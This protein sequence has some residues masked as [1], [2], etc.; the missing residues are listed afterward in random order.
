MSKTKTLGGIFAAI[1][2]ALAAWFGMSPS[3]GPG[4]SPTPTA[5]ATATPEPTPEPTASPTPTPGPLPSPSVP[6]EIDCPINPQAHE[7]EDRPDGPLPFREDI[8]NAINKAMAAGFVV[9]GKIV[10]EKAYTDAVARF[11][12]QVGVCAINGSLAGFTGQDEIWLKD[13]SVS[14]IHVDIAS[15]AG[16][17]IVLYAAKCSPPA[18]D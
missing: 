11:L 2:A 13:G 15:A 17:P 10:D 6:V 12:R 3:P 7:C 4:P 14:S 8:E 9:N 18:F 1:L 5:T 16:H